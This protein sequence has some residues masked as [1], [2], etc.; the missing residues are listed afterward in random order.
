MRYTI[1]PITPYFIDD[2]GIRD[3]VH[4]CGEERPDG[5]REGSLARARDP[6]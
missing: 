4:V 1:Q 3:H 6:Q 5:L 2:E